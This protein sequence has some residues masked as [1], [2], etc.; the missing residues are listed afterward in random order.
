MTKEQNPIDD[1]IAWGE[2][3]IMELRIDSARGEW[4]RLDNLEDAINAL[5]ASRV[6]PSAER[7]QDRSYYDGARQAASMAHQSL[8]AMDEWINAGCGGRGPVVNRSVT[9]EGD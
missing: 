3:V 2:L 5:K 4:D 9:H 8:K 1:V 7:L 6:E